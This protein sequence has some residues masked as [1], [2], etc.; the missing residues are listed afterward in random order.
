MLEDLFKPVDLVN[1]LEVFMQTY[2][3]LTTTHWS[4]VVPCMAI[5]GLQCRYPDYKYFQPVH[6]VNTRTQTPWKSDLCIL[7]HSR[8]LSLLQCLT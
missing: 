2:S 1:T 4:T 8:S 5:T 3:R 6:C 7:S